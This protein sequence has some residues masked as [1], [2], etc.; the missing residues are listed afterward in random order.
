[1]RSSP[2]LGEFLSGVWEGRKKAGMRDGRMSG[3]EQEC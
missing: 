3:C 2:I 1:M